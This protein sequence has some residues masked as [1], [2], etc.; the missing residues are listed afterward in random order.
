MIL[1]PDGAG[2]HVA[3]DLLVPEGIEPAL[4]PPH[5]PEVQPAEHPWPMVSEPVANTCPAAL[6]G[7]HEVVGERRRALADDLDRIRA[8]ARFHRRPAFASPPLHG[9]HYARLA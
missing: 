7:L 8:S 4:L 1:V 6:D 9:S 5:S 2:R 3:S